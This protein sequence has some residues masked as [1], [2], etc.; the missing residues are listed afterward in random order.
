MILR[1][2]AVTLPKIE[3]IIVEKASALDLIIIG[4]GPAGLTAG[5][6]AIRARLKTLL[7]E[8]ALLG[9]QVSL[10]DTVENY[11]GFPEGIK[12]MELAKRMEDQARRLGL[13]IIWGTASELEIE[14]TL[15]KITINGKKLSTRALIIATG[16][17][18]KKLGVPG[19]D[20][21][22][23]RGVSYCAVCDA[24]F[25]RDKKVVVVGGGDSAIQEALFLSKYAEI[26]TVVHRRDQLRANKIF[27]ERA[28]LDPKIYF[29][30]HTSIEEIK[31]KD[32]VEEV[33]VRD[34]LTN[35]KTKIKTD[36]VFIYIG[37]EPD[38][39]F[40]K[41]KIKLDDQGFIITDEEMKTS[42]EGVFAAGDVRRKSLRQIATA[43]GDGAMAVDSALKYLEK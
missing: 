4:G 18:P 28:R 34:V 3:A 43:V 25:Y 19:E 37:K 5:I 33:V 24:P 29:M 15:K 2:E 20:K 27:E 10:T 31:G 42:I 16:G 7:I 23:G 35:K 6:Y 21:F 36:G 12:G 11:P 26:V 1:E 8:K 41:D 30:W 17:E 13:E 14:G 38:T 40:V 32:K 22:R 39:E 9:G